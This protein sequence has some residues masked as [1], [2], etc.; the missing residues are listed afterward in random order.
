MHFR[1]YVCV[2]VQQQ[3]IF[4]RNACMGLRVSCNNEGALCV[5][6]PCNGRATGALPPLHPRL[7][8]SLC[9]GACRSIVRPAGH[10]RLPGA[11]VM[12]GGP[13]AS[14]LLSSRAP[15]LGSPPLAGGG[16]VNAQ[17]H[18]LNVMVQRETT[19]AAACPWQ[20]APR[21]VVKGAF[22]HSA[23]TAPIST[24]IIQVTT[25]KTTHL[26]NHAQSIQ[27][28]KIHTSDACHGSQGPTFCP[29]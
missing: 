10:K 19:C 4:L 11:P 15:R 8:Q 27:N 18:W 12:G 1:V 22:S 25:L 21:C 13:S 5:A 16:G 7:S 2:N 24:V 28:S 17:M 3:H 26:R 14:A 20:M 29:L 9:A 23:G 6:L